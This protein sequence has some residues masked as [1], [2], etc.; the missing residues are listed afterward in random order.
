MISRSPPRM[1]YSMRGR[2]LLIFVPILKNTKY[3]CFMQARRGKA[4][5]FPILAEGGGQGGASPPCGVWGV[6][7]FP[8]SSPPKAVQRG[9]WLLVLIER[10]IKKFFFKLLPDPHLSLGSRQRLLIPRG[11]QHASRNILRETIKMWLLNRIGRHEAEL[12][13][14]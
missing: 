8:L 11:L 4:L 10:E 9:S 3:L 14:A 5:S 7:A 2:L 13:A 1:D 12:Y 6:P